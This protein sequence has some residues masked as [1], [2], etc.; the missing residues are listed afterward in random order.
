ML[1]T[2]MTNW[3]SRTAKLDERH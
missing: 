2:K 3:L 1:F